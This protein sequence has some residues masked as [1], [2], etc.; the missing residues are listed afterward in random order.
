[1]P[2]LEHEV[3]VSNY[4]VRLQSPVHLREVN[5]SLPLM[6]LHGIPAAQRDMRA[7]F[8]GKV[9]EVSLP[10]GPAATPRLLSRNLCMLIGP[11]VERKKSTS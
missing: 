3:I 9:N 10:A 7:A 1:V 11:N 8:A 2:E 6:D 5:R 4:A